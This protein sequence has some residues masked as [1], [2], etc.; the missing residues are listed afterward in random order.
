MEIKKDGPAAS[1]EDAARRVRDAAG[2][3]VSDAKHATLQ[4][5]EDAR[6]KAGDKAHSA[7]SRFRDLAGQV[8]NEMPWMATAFKKSADGLDNVTNSL[9]SGDI[10]QCLAGVS[11]FAKRQPAVFLGASVAIG[12]ALARIGKTALEQAQPASPAKTPD[13]APFDGIEGSYATGTEI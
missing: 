2:E 8:E 6:A 5:V 4:G 11:D 12:F 1:L 7:A 13:R 9:T 10:N 3:A